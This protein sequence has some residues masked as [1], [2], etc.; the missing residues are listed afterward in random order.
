MLEIWKERN[1]RTSVKSGTH[2]E[3]WEVSSLFSFFFSPA[4]PPS[5]I[6]LRPAHV[7]HGGEEITICLTCIEFRGIHSKR[8]QSNG[9]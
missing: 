2:N 1:K 8:L 7:E 9:Y 3:A 5:F 4:Q 6:R